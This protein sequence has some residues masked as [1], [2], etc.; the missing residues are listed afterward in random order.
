MA[1]KVKEL[2]AIQIKR[3]SKPG[4]YAAG[5]ATGLYLNVAS[6][7]SRSWILRGTI[8]SKRRDMG[9]G[10]YPD[11]SLQKAREDA[12]EYRSQ[13]RRGI[14]PINGRRADKTALKWAQAKTISFQ[15][16]AYQCHAKKLP[17]FKNI[18]HG[19]EWIRTLER[20]AFPVLGSMPVGE[21]EKTHLLKLLE[22]IWQTKTETATR[23]RQRIET[24]LSWA[25]ASGSRSG[26]NPA[27]WKDNLEPLLPTPS[28]ITKVVHHPALPWQ[29]IGAFMG[30]LRNR[31]G[32]A[33]RALEFAILTA[34]RSGEVRGMVWS[35]VDLVSKLWIVPEERTKS[36]RD[37]KVPLSDDAIHILKKLTRFE[38]IDFV[39]A[40]PRGG[41]LSD[42]ALLAVMKRMNVPAV[43]HGFRSTF[44]DWARSNTAYP[45]EVS[46][47]ALAHV[48]SD[49]TRAAYARDE[50]LP[51]R[52]KLMGDWAK[53]CSKAQNSGRVIAIR[54]SK[55]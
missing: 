3:L 23:V 10:G 40:A 45:D 39:F 54:G 15:E 25:S 52:Q 48:N 1:G 41:M 5:G 53:F 37:H 44:K 42:V 18:K 17:E 24:V 34:A 46:E 4:L 55:A 6:G 47:L 29:K 35:E 7:G 12:K 9:L 36:K 21:I 2:T 28:K 38:G 16:A 14:D 31:N 8:G 20:H 50:L 30:E 13:M 22:P 49:S 27:R 51:K 11:I 26:E 32:I 43:P 19:K 33:A